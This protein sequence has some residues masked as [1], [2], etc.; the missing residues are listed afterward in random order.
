MVHATEEILSERYLL[1]NFPLNALSRTCIIKQ[2]LS[3]KKYSGHDS[4]CEF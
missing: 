1:I 2:H 4:N 3:I